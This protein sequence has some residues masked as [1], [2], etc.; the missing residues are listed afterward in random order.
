M[1][2]TPEMIRPLVAIDEGLRK[3][4][5][6]SLTGVWGGRLLVEGKEG[7]EF[8]QDDISAGSVLFVQDLPKGSISSRKAGFEFYK[9]GEDQLV[10]K[11]LLSFPIDVEDISVTGAAVPQVRKSITAVCQRYQHESQH[12]AASIGYSLL[13]ASVQIF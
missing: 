5:N 4:W 13:W 11:H 10:R 3:Q 2:I 12:V 7:T 6:Y 9:N 1:H 8:S